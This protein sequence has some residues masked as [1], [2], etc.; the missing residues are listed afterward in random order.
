MNW[1]ERAQRLY[2]YETQILGIV[3]G[4]LACSDVS[5][6]GEGINTRHLD[7]FSRTE[8]GFTVFFILPPP[9]HPPGQC[10]LVDME[11]ISRVQK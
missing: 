1:F 7:T 8:L 11:T 5:G 4:D 3:A 2:V 6:F 10:H 9:A